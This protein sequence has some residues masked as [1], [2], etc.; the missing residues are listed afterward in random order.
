MATHSSILA[1]EIPWKRSL[2]GY[3]PWGHKRV[4]HDWATHFSFMQLGRSCTHLLQF[5]FLNIYWELTMWWMPCWACWGR[6]D[7][8]L[9][10]LWPI[11]W[12]LY[13][14]LECSWPFTLTSCLF[15]LWI[16]SGLHIFLSTNYLKFYYTWQIIN[17]YF[18][19]PQTSGRKSLSWSFWK[20]PL[21]FFVDSYPLPSVA[22]LPF[23]L[24]LWKAY[25]STY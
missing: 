20:G 8:T 22:T 21:T 18:T 17:N 9:W 2:V 16:F 7:I 19:L 10:L 14:Y 3:S 11:F 6:H 23:V 1:W 13:F 4:R 12:I 25:L 15:S 5:D 24:P